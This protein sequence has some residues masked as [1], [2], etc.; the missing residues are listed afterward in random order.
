MTSPASFMFFCLLNLALKT[1]EYEGAE[2]EEEPSDQLATWQKEFVHNEENSSTTAS[3]K[4]HAHDGAVVIINT[5]RCIVHET[6]YLLRPHSADNGG[7]FSNDLIAHTPLHLS[8]VMPSASFSGPRRGNEKTLRKKKR[9]A[10]YGSSSDGSFIGKSAL[11]FS[12]SDTVL[13]VRATSSVYL[14]ALSLRQVTVF[15]LRR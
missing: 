6:L 2:I 4:W 9:H 1:L 15:W 7:S 8:D 13:F 5:A 3:R 14:H 10:K 11:N 12:V